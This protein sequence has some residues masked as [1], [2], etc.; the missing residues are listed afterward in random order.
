MLNIQYLKNRMNDIQQPKEV[1]KE[2]KYVN[3]EEGK[4][5]KVRFLPMEN[6]SFC[7][8]YWLYYGIAKQFFKCT[9]KLN[10]PDPIHE[11][12][13]KI[14]QDPGLSNNWN[15]CKPFKPKL[16]CAAPVIVRGEEHKGVQVFTFNEK[17]YGDLISIFIHEKY[18]NAV[19]P[20]NG[21]DI[22]VKAYKK[23]KWLRFDIKG[24]EWSTQLNMD[25]SALT[26]DFPDLDKI[27]TEYDYDRMNEY[28]RAYNNLNKPQQFK[29]EQSGDQTPPWKSSWNQN[30]PAWQPNQYNEQEKVKPF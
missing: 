18:Q 3:F 10:K 13:L 20:V 5:Y 16:R 29:T 26:D 30:Q 17:I 8:E 22:V 7:N 15:Y 14:Q 2:I 12:F 27:Y 25:I 6:G 24:D 28:L 11:E 4:T 21:F 19:D 9:H 1:E 23:D